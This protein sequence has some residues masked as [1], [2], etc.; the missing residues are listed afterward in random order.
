M[1]G[2]IARGQDGKTYETVGQ[3]FKKSWENIVAHL[4]QNEPFIAYI[5]VGEGYHAV[6]ITGATY[7]IDEA[8]GEWIPQT[9]IFRNPAPNKRS[10]IVFT[11]EKFMG[12]ADSKLTTLTMQP[13]V[14]EK[15]V[16]DVIERAVGKTREIEFLETDIAT[17][18]ETYIATPANTA[19]TWR[20][21]ITIGR[22]SIG[23]QEFP[24]IVRQE[25]LLEAD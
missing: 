17:G 13:Y 20:A 24:V 23:G 15:A 8:T 18:E 6:V 3:D 10:R 12:R 14:R 21:K 5:S 7:N 11:W 25:N 2:W 1:S 4:Q 19:A 16:T 22:K 9:I